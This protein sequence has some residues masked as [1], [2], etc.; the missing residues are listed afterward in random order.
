MNRLSVIAVGLIAS[1]LL[2][3]ASSAQAQ[4]KSDIEMM[5]GFLTL[6]SNYLAIIEETHAVSDNPEMAAI[7]QMQKI[8][9]VYEERGEKAKSIDIL[10]SVLNETD[11]PAIRNGA[12]FLLGDTLKETGRHEEAIQLLQQG[13]AE[14][15]KRAD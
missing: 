15:I 7:L 8:Q 3:F 14:N 12:Y 5:N 9:E 6:I 1:T 2:V 4:S 11:N 13:L 10:K